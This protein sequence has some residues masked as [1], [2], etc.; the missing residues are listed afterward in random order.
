MCCTGEAR[1]ICPERHLNH[2]DNTII[3]TFDYQPYAWQKSSF[4]LDGCR[5]VVIRGNNF[6]DQYKTR[7]VDIE[8]MQKRDLKIEKKQKILIVY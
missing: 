2:I 1:I 7:S 5:D 4:L 8:H 3:K 6:S